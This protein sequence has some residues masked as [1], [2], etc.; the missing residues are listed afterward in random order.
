MSRRYVSRP[1]LSVGLL[2][3]RGFE[4]HMAGSS[5]LAKAGKR[6]PLTWWG[7]SRCST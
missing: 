3:Q 6:V 7:V 4:A 5:Y 2:R 1:L